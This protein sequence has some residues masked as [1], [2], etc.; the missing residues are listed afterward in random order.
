MKIEACNNYPFGGTVVYFGSDKP[1]CIANQGMSIE[2][3]N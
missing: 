1:P 3:V 2:G